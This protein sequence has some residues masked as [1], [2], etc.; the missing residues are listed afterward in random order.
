MVRPIAKFSIFDF[1]IWNFEKT[2]T[3][4]ISE[5]CQ[6]GMTICSSIFMLLNMLFFF[7]GR[8]DSIVVFRISILWQADFILIYFAYLHLTKTDFD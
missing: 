3:S 5:E 2:A 1:R 4:L 6:F 7:D 8:N